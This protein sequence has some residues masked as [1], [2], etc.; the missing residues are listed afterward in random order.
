MSGELKH[1]PT[2]SGSSLDRTDWESP[3]I[4]TLDGAE[5][6]DLIFFNGQS[7]V[8]LPHGDV[9]G[10]VLQTGGHGANPFWGSPL[11]EGLFGDGSDGDVTISSDTNLTRDMFYNNLTINSS[12]TLFTKGYKIFVKGIFNNHGIIDNSAS[13]NSGAPEGTLGGGGNGGS[14]IGGSGYGG[15]GG[16][17]IYIVAKAIINNGT[18]R[19]NGANGRN[20]NQGTGNSA[21]NPGGAVNPGLGGNG[22]KG[23]NAIGS[24]T[25][26]AGGVVTQSTVVLHHYIPLLTFIDSA[27]KIGGGGGGGSGGTYSY[28]G[29]CGG[30]G[31][32]GGG[33]ILILYGT[34]SWGTEEAN[35]GMG[36]NGSSGGSKGQDGAPGNIYKIKAQ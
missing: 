16:G 13:Y 26:G 10:Q 6:G 3:L 4:H 14:G 2:A 8:R 15:G 34:A 25:G 17:I 22:G 23:G 32:G 36:G 28:T 33:L 19:A 20:A 29:A 12:V 11:N 31:G 21:G 35:G 30:G 9:P 24:Y 7:L 1:N 18:I 27:G 5:Q